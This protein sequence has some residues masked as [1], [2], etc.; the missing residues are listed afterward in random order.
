MTSRT[1]A[2]S[3]RAWAR[4]ARCSQRSS[5]EAGAEVL[6]SDINNER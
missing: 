2:S 1:S 5:P 4:S 3:S 6:V